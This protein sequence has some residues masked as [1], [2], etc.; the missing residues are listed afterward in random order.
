ME[1]VKGHLQDSYPFLG[2]HNGDNYTN[3]FFI[4]IYENINKIR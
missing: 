2:A 1:E 4:V 3:K